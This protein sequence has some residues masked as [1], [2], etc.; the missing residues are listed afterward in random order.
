MSDQVLT[1]R[2]S[3]ELKSQLN[4]LGEALHRSKSY[5]AEKAIRLYVEQNIWQIQELLKAEEEIKQGKF[6]S[7]EEVNQYLDSWKNT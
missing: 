4:Q 3:S 2:V 5:I 6:M 1:I 7:D